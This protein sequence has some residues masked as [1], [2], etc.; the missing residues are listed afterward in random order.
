MTTLYGAIQ[1]E[2]DSLYS[3]I[4]LSNVKKP[5]KDL[6]DYQVGEKVEARCPGFGIFM[7]TIRGISDKSTLFYWG[8]WYL[9][10]GY[11]F[12]IVSKQFF[13]CVIKKSTTDQ[14]FPLKYNSSILGTKFLFA[15]S[16]VSSRIF[17]FSD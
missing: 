7:G 3:V 16:F 11:D 1:W 14:F 12:F 9:G 13:F 6:A 8:I 10:E 5:R 4:A 17:F 15:A 2:V